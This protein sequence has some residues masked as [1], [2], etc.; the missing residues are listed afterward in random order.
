MSGP[1]G[2]VCVVGLWHLGTVVAACLAERGRS[3]TALEFDT[4][5]RA[6]LAA[7]RSPVAEPLVDEL[8][9][10]GLASG[11]LAVTG[12]PA[13]VRAARHVWFAY[14]V[15]VDDE[16]RPDLGELWSAVRHVAPHLAPDATVVVSSQVPVGTCDRIA[17]ELRAGNPRWRGAIAY[18][19]ENL[20]LGAAVERFR[21]PDFV[22]VGT[23]DDGAGA[24][25]DSVVELFGEPGCPV[26]RVGL[27]TAELVK[28][29]VNAALATSISLG[30]QLAD[31]AEAAGADGLAVARAMR[32]DP[33]IGSRAPVL[34]GL[35]FA[36]GTLARDLRSLQE[37]GRRAD[38]STGL[39]DAV[40][41]VNAGRLDRLVE[42]V[43]ARVGGLAGA[44]VA[45]LGLT[46]TAGTSTV[47]RSDSAAL[48]RLLLDRGATV[49]AHDPAARPVG[50]ELPAGLD[51]RPDPYAAA[52]QAQAVVL[53]TPW[54]Q[55]RSL[56]LARLTAG[57]ARPP[58]LV[59]P[60]HLFA[61][62]ARP[63]GLS[64]LAPGRTSEGGPA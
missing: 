9:R 28:H 40:L 46:Y 56:D 59:D 53:M 45:V 41:T 54:P 38:T 63:A 3:V 14:D 18:S 22:V 31:L 24:A 39:F 2:G 11:R 4:D 20:R 57:M 52:E 15:A 21:R 34:P 16:D 25:G 62:A 49:T 48:V 35:G 10:A 47:R 5:R 43:S 7:G 23:D 32:L 13:A 1:A 55:Y 61:D 60:H 44:R 26:V 51:R 6:A 17:A 30:N 27:R 36:G 42:A 58:L 37:L 12:D 64:Y 29:A 19:P 50:T 33:R 8:L